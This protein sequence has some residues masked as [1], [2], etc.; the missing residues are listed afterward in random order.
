MKTAKELAYKAYYDATAHSFRIDDEI[1]LKERFENWWIEH[2]VRGDHK[3][4]F[5]HE[6]NV[7]VD[8][9]RYMQVE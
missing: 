9:K 5:H 8:G 4:S 1:T 6:H 7:Y 3:D 2:Y